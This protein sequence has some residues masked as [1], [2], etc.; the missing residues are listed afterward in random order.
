MHVEA[1]VKSP[2]DGGSIPPASIEATCDNCRMWLFSL[3]LTDMWRPFVLA[4]FGIGAFYHPF[5]GP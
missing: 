3:G 1:L 4:N 2:Q 5:L